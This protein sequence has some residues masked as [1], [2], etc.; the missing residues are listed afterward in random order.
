MVQKQ[1]H[2]R[3]PPE[4]HLTP[5]HPPFQRETHDADFTGIS[6]RIAFDIFEALE[7]EGHKPMDIAPYLIEFME[8]NTSKIEA[9]LKQIA[10]RVPLN[11]T[12]QENAWQM[13]GN[14]QSLTPAEKA[15]A[16]WELEITPIKEHCSIWKGQRKFITDFHNIMGRFRAD[17]ATIEV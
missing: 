4:K 10:Y 9:L 17:M 12:Q 8:R 1:Q 11:S 15:R 14:L 5:Q 13:L 2:L 6:P 7:A 16:L 3:F